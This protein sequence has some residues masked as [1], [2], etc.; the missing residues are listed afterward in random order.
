MNN[1]SRP[2]AIGN[3]TIEEFNS[4]VRN[5]GCYTVRVINH[6]ADYLGPA[7][8]VFSARLY[9]QS[10]SY[11]QY[12]RNSLTGVSTD[13]SAIFFTSWMGGKM[14]SSLVCT[15]LISFWNRVQGKTGRCINSTVVHT[16]TTTSI[17]ENIPNFAN[18]TANL[19]C[20]TLK[21]AQENYHVYDRQR[22]VASTSANKSVAQ[23][24]S[25]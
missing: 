5:D 12:F 1:A 23:R 24:E 14:D 13:E 6:Q 7:S 3:M 19:L 22:K 4:A 2:G 16:F 8:T 17:H 20:H 11:F 15:Q 25:P 21:I 18:D 10:K 9:D